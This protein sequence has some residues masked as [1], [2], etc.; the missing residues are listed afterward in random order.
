MGF[1][2]HVKLSDSKIPAMRIHFSLWFLFRTNWHEIHR[3]GGMFG[4]YNGN[5]ITLLISIFD[6]SV[7]IIFRIMGPWRFSKNVWHRCGR[8]FQGLR[9]TSLFIR[10]LTKLYRRK[11]N[12]YSTYNMYRQWDGGKKEK[13]TV[14]T[15]HSF[16][17]SRASYIASYSEYPSWWSHKKLERLN[18][19]LK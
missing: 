11:N 6:S 16:N 5:L 12:K 4:L 7:T 13:A 18:I 1:R 15:L 8:H 10:R 19:C 9:M 3:C 17:V 2:W 14:L